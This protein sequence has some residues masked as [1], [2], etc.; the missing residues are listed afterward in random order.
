MLLTAS[1]S[2]RSCLYG[3]GL[4]ETMAYREGKLVYWSYHWARLQQGLRRLLY[5]DVSEDQVFAVL[6]PH[7]D[8]LPEDS[9]IRLT[10]TRRG[11][12]GYR[13]L[14]DAEVEIEVQMSPF[15]TQRW[16]GRGIKAR[17]CNTTWAQQPL[18]AGIKHLNRLEQVLARSEWA[19]ADIE[20]GLVCDTAGYV[21]SGTMSAILVRYGQLVFAADISQTGID[22]VARQVVMA[23]LPAL[24]YELRVRHLSV[25]DVMGADEVLMMNAVQGIAFV[26]E[27]G[28]YMGRS[29][30]LI[31][32]LV[33]CFK[34]AQDE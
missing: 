1:S 13:A 25:E 23:A 31:S 6:Q 5:P 17:W 19:D 8:L 20:E 30:Q 14:P 11:A 12:R 4:F 18:L 24:G 26:S 27:C 33:A 32:Q 15:P 34:G 3:D 10:V 22:S 28:C 2:L 9:V 29:R 21:I 16:H 7:L